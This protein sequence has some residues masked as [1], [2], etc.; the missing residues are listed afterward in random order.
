M[1]STCASRDGAPMSHEIV[2]KK[3]VASHQIY[4]HPGP[5][6]RRYAARPACAGEGNVPRSAPYSALM[7]AALTIF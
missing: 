2:E 7:P 5:A 4:P 1:A 3:C 6:R